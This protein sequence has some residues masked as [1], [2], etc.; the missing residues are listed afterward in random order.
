MEFLVS[1]DPSNGAFNN[2]PVKKPNHNKKTKFK[3]L[4]N[5]IKKPKNEKENEKKSING[6]GGGEFEKVVK[7]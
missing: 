3:D 7:I 6:L 2:T 1:C 4:L 5:E